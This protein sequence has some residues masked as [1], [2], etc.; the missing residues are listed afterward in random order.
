MP[1]VTILAY[2]TI[3]AH[4]L[5]HG[6]RSG[7]RGYTSVQ[8]HDVPGSTPLCAR[9][10]F[11]AT[12]KQPAYARDNDGMHNGSV[13]NGQLCMLVVCRIVSCACMIM[14]CTM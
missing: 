7:S 12:R 4:A 9:G 13:H 1:I 2:Q 11:Q 14:S 5:Y 8:P 3:I 6:K 10:G